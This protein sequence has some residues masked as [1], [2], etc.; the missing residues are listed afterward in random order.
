MTKK[1][2]ADI[3]DI[4]LA[5]ESNND[6]EWTHYLD[7]VTG[8]VHFVDNDTWNTLDEAW[9]YSEDG[10]E[11]PSDD[12]LLHTLKTLDVDLPDDPESFL[13]MVRILTD[14]QSRYLEIPVIESYEAYN[15][16]TDFAETVSNPILYGKLEVALNGRGAFRRFK[17]VLYQYPEE[18][19]RWYAFER[20]AYVNDIKRWLSHEGYELVGDTQTGNLQN[21]AG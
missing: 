20:H 7:T 3:E 21:D 12:A 4:L 1:I 5:Y 17:D 14:R 11:T 18:Q 15:V 10:S 19:Q 6:Y 13:Y 8:E 9:P 2:Q 16:M